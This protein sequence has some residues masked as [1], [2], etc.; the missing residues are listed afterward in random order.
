[1]SQMHRPDI[2][3]GVV[4]NE[5]THRVS[6][7][8]VQGAHDFIGKVLTREDNLWFSQL[9]HRAVWHVDGGWVI[10]YRKDAPSEAILIRRV[11]N[12]GVCRFSGMCVDGGVEIWGLN[13]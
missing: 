13:A 8:V 11:I 2:S 6:V 1:M 12:G 5:V 10:G 9:A 4:V 7:C 3:I